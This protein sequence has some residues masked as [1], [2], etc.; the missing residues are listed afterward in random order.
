MRAALCTLLLA[1][2]GAALA[3]CADCRWGPLPARLQLG[4]ALELEVSRPLRDGGTPLEALRLDAL[5]HDF[6][7]FERTIGQSAQ[8][9]DMRLTLYARHSGTLPLALP[10]HPPATIEVVSDGPVQVEFT[11]Q[12]EPADWVLRRS[13]RLTLE[14]CSRGALRW[15][16]PA[17]AIITGLT[18]LPLNPQPTAETHEARGCVPQRWTWSATPSLPGTLRVE[19]GMLKAWRHGQALRF[20]S[21]P[22]AA[23]VAAVP[24]W[25]PA[26][27]A[28]T[29]PQIVHS[30]A[31]R[32]GR[33]DEAL[34]W[35]LRLRAGYSESAL[36]ALL[37]AQLAGDSAWARYPARIS[38]VPDGGTD[39]WDIRLST[40]PDMHG[41]L[42]L[43]QLRLPWFDA[44][45]GELR[46]VSLEAT[47][48]LI[49]DP[50]RERLMLAAGTTGAL[51]LLLIAAGLLRHPV[52]ARRE[53][54]RLLARVA[55]AR[56]ADALHAALLGPQ[57]GA[58]LQ[59]WARGYLT[60][61][62]APDLPALTAR[63]DALRFGRA[64]TDE[65]A[66][67]RTRLLA[68]LR[69][70]RPVSRRTLP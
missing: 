14:A 45:R 22:Y 37:D 35:T 54:R 11:W 40:I 52:R 51:A 58:S 15:E 34:V 32:E 63:V 68:C 56:D 39:L 61:H 3:D 49:R 65:F 2:S 31:P 10:G 46:H 13:G 26:G 29:E 30:D 7:I 25:L 24:A 23:Q 48:S 27:I 8:G 4:E 16:R 59:A 53:R 67:L 19:L 17:P 70:A 33:V 28:L 21:P 44:A 20:P 12:A 36:T 5:Q 43:P 9:E 47:A 38:T 64:A 69:S 57:A 62:T 41:S 66:Q 50:L 55:R 18:L 6:E 60:T 1:Y 42:A